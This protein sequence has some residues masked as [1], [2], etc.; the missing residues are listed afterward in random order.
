MFVAEKVDI[1]LRM[2]TIFGYFKSER[3]APEPPLLLKKN[4]LKIIQ[5]PTKK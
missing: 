2:Q 5:I 1:I 3:F 4:S